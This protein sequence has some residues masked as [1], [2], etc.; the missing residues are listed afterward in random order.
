MGARYRRSRS[1]GSSSLRGAHMMSLSRPKAG[2]YVTVLS[3]FRTRQFVRAYVCESSAQV[4]TARK[5]TGMPWITPDMLLESERGITW[6]IGLEG[7]EVEALYVA[8]ALL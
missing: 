3:N 7:A 6:A 5:R 8:T 2:D 4:L 1:G